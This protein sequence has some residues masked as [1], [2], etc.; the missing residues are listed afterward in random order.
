MES[1]RKEARPI[2]V[3][4]IQGPRGTQDLPTWQPLAF[5]PKSVTDQVKWERDLNHTPH[6][7]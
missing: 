2:G 1:Q 6:R 3:G 7:D 5:S 4:P